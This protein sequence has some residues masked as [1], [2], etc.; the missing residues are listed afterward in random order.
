[1]TSD[2]RYS[3][4]SKVEGYFDRSEYI[5]VRDVFFNCLLL[6]QRQGNFL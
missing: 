4:N 2:I 6:K 5:D 1:M 3:G